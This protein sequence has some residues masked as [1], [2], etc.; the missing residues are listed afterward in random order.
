MLD[1]SPAES[2]DNL[3]LV[4][5]VRAFVR[6]EVEPLEEANRD[7][8]EN[9]RL[10]YDERGGYCQ[11]VVDL[12]RA[13]RM[14]S[15]KSGYYGMFAP[16]SV[17][18]G[19][20]GFLTWF[21]VWEGL[22]HEFGP[23]RLLPYQSVA[24]WTSGPSFLLAE[25]RQEI[26]D[27]VIPKIMSGEASLCFALSEPD[28]GSDVWAMRTRA[29]ADG[30]G[31]IL[32]GTKQWIS[33]SPHADYAY[34]FAVT[35]DAMRKERS[36]GIT[37]FLVDTTWPGYQVDSVIRLYDQIGGNE[38]ILSFSDMRIP[39]TYVVGEVDHGFP[40]ALRGVSRGRMYNAGRC[41]GLARW[42]LEKATSY[43]RERRAFGQ[44][45]GSYQGVS[46]M[47]AES[48]T[49]IYAAR[50]MAKDCACRLDGGERV[51][52][53]LAM[54]KLFATEMCSRVFDRCMQVCG[55]MGITNEMK[56]VDGWHQA[57]TSRLAAGS[58]EIMRRTIAGRLLKGDVDL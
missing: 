28:A 23:S 37:C 16:S 6:R 52:K 36:G 38:G 53:E 3:A 29:V 21:S 33:D 46:F 24:H 51:L 11:A 49:E 57:R 31:W 56:M 27:T 35:D 1:S 2:V 43:A 22:N 47:L 12:L 5:G 30:D 10:T 40:L 15:A 45:I 48:A 18:G 50:M 55:G 19:D 20:L 13:V 4:Q 8:L 26:T 39:A 17:G 41:V 58:S 34:V 54:T 14:A 44:T 7:L 9:P 32:N 25:G 42:A